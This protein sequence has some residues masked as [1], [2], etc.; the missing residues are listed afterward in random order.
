MTAA[1]FILGFV[2]GWLVPRDAFPWM[3]RA[4]RW[5]MFN[6]DNKLIARVVISV[7]LAVLILAVAFG[8]SK[9]EIPTTTPKPTLAAWIPYTGKSMLPTLPEAGLAEIEIGVTFDQLKQGD[10]V[11]FWD[12]LRGTGKF[13]LHRL[14]AKQ[15]GN[16][17]AQGDN[18][19]TNPKA[20]RPWVTPDN[21]VARA[22]GKNVQFV[23]A[24]V[25]P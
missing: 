18:P 19:E 5:L 14:V 22:T 17:I 13:T 20:D 4:S 23:W 8:C 16:W 1:A 21:Y 6:R 10:I 15:A 3:K 12:Y 24:P 7:A 9:R 2:L 11:V 25:K